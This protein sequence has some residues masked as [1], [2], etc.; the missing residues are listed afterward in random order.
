MPIPELSPQ[1]CLLAINFWL[2]F[3]AFCVGAP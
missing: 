1:H 2:L 3:F